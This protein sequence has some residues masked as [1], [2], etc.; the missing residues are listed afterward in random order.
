MTKSYISAFS[1]SYILT[2]VKVKVFYPQLAQRANI[3]V[4]DNITATQ[5]HAVGISLADRQIKLR[6]NDF[7]SL[8]LKSLAYFF[9]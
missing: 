9:V 2:I 5:Y 6:R 3:T 4:E 8:R 1:R 7:L